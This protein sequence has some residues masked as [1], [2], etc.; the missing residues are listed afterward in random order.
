MRSLNAVVCFR[1]AVFCGDIAIYPSAPRGGDVEFAPMA[2]EYKRQPV[3]RCSRV[4]LLKSLLRPP[5]Q[6]E[7]SVCMPC[8]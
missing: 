7:F 3:W 4:L 6:A 5:A 8:S 1:E 2:A